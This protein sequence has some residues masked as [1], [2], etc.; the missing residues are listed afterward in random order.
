MADELTDGELT[1]PA[2]D[3]AAIKDVRSRLLVDAVDKWMKQLVDVSGNNR[4]LFYKD[5]K[6]GTLDLSKSADK[7]SLDSLLSGRRVRLSQLFT[8]AL[9]R[10]DASS[11]MRT[12]VAKSK[13][14][15]EER[16]LRT[17]YLAWGMAT[18]AN[19]G[20]AATPAAPVLLSEIFVQQ[21]GGTGEDFDIELVGDWQ[22]NPTLVH[23]LD[24]ECGLVLNVD[25]YVEITEE[26]PISATKVFD[27][28]KHDVRESFDRSPMAA[29][30]T[31]DTWLRYVRHA[32]AEPTMRTISRPSITAWK[33]RHCSSKRTSKSFRSHPMEIGWNLKS[34]KGVAW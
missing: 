27:K 22:I 33:Q 8:S 20:S 26:I 10:E 24:A 5:L 15:F 19:S 1:P 31:P 2:D 21:R 3:D 29:Q 12:V 25:S 6:K 17:M 7:R 23:Y 32:T 34:E 28:L 9:S 11:R 30:T 18:W 16:G 14:Y 4:L 13:E